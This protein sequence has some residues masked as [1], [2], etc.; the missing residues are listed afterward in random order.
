MASALCWAIDGLYDADVPSEAFGKLSIAADDTRKKDD[1]KKGRSRL[2]Q[3]QANRKGHGY[4]SGMSTPQLLSQLICRSTKLVHALVTHPKT[5]AIV[6]P[7]ARKLA[8]PVSPGPPTTTHPGTGR[9]AARNGP[10]APNGRNTTRGV[11]IRP[12]AL[13]ALHSRASLNA[14][15]VHG[16][17]SRHNLNP[18]IPNP[19]ASTVRNMTTALPQRYL[20]SLGRLDFAEEDLV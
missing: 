6:K 8:T 16:Q 10:R 5:S 9:G 14:A 3:G 12:T 4:D 2:A 17:N 20:V 19:H 7:I 1:I 11:P 18:S 13:H 15:A